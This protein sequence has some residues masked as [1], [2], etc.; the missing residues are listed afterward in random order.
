VDDVGI[1]IT[2][3][4]VRFLVVDRYVD[5]TERV[6]ERFVDQFSRAI[7]LPVKRGFERGDDVWLGWLVLHNW[8][9]VYRT[10]M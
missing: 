6:C 5:C 10:A 1:A 8:I 7:E 9:R 4:D 2:V 3:T